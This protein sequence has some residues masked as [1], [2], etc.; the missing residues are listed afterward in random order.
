MKNSIDD[1]I[2]KSIH[3]VLIATRPEQPALVKCMVDDFRGNKIADKFYSTDLI[4]NTSK[5]Q[6]EIEPYV[7][8]AEAKCNIALFLQSPLGIFVLIAILLLLIICC[9]CIIKCICC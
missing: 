7:D 9:C 1:A 4:L 5:L 6:E 2:Y 3:G 8:V